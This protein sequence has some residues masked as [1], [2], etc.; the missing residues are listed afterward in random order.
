MLPWQLRSTNCRSGPRNDRHPNEGYKLPELLLQR[1]GF[2]GIAVVAPLVV[3]V[4]VAVAARVVVVVLAAV[5]LVHGD[6][7]IVVVLV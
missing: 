6:H 4:E 5:L 1:M 7:S 2:P 3:V